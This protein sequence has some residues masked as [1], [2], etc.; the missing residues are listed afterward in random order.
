[1]CHAVADQT[2]AGCPLPL[3][4]PVVL[5]MGA[6]LLGATVGRDEVED[7]V[8]GAAISSN[9]GVFSAGDVFGG[10]LWSFSLWFTR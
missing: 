5:L 2:T 4:W 3:S 7:I 9:I 1:M 10:L 8:Y 6:V